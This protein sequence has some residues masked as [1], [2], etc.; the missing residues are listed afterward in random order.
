MED[1]YVRKPVS[2]SSSISIAVMPDMLIVGGTEAQ[3]R[4][5]LLGKIVLEEAQAVWSKL[6][7]VPSLT[8]TT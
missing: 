7:I 2:D 8:T 5:C 4:F 6:L 1:N 3:R